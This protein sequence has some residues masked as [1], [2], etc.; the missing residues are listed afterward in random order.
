MVH[1]KLKNGSTYVRHFALG[2]LIMVQAVC[3]KNGD[4]KKT[5]QSQITKNIP[6]NK[7]CSHLDVIWSKGFGQG[8]KI[9]IS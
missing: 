8:E 2:D 1:V 4:K 5:N 6:A 9:K 7:G 3:S